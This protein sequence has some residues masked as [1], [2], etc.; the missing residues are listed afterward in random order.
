[1]QLTNDDGIGRTEIQ[2]ITRIME[3]NHDLILEEWYGYFGN[4]R[5][6]AMRFVGRSW[7][8]TYSCSP[9]SRLTLSRESEIAQSLV[10]S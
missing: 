1:M 3:S 10:E 7:T 2:P 6:M 5:A 9:H 8:N 4:L